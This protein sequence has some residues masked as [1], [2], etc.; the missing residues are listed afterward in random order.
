MNDWAPIETAPE[1]GTWILG[2]NKEGRQAKIQSRRI[3]P[4][5][6]L[7]AWFEGEPEQHGEWQ[8]NI[9][10]YPVEWCAL[11]VAGQQP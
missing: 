10:F 5:K 8:R 9:C 6:D 3:H 4:K 7:R 1:N 11:P 2:R